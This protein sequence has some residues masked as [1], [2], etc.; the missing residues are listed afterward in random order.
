[1]AIEA[2]VRPLPNDETTPPVT[3]IY[4]AVIG[5]ILNEQGVTCTVFLA[6]AKLKI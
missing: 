5:G 6:L 4:F 2:A 3:K 1:M